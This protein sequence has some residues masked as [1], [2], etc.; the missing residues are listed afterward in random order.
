MNHTHTILKQVLLPIFVTASLSCS[1]SPENPS[2]FVGSV[3]I[4]VVDKPA[5]LNEFKITMNRVEFHR[6]DATAELGWR[7]VTDESQVFNLL[8]LRNGI[9]LT[10][11]NKD[12]PTGLYDKIRMFFG[13]VTVRKADN[14]ERAVTFAPNVVNGFT[15]DFSF[16]ILESQNYQLIFDFD[17]SRSVKE[18]ALNQFVFLP[19]IRIQPTLQSGSISGSISPPSAAALVL[20]TVK[21]DTVSTY[22]DTTALNGSFQLVALPPALYDLRILPGNFSLRETTITGVLV[23][24][25][26]DTSVGQ[27]VL[28]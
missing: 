21:G 16:S 17:A 3:K 5:A 9:R 10:I 7:V 28:R 13:A 8:L 20:T 22:A 18:I 14:V 15:V 25:Q 6:S 11:A 1:E 12:V 26:V 19:V 4:E 2:T 27:I 24:A 23:R